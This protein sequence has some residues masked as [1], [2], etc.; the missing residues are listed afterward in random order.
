MGKIWRRTRD[1]LAIKHQVPQLKQIPLRNLRQYY[2]TN[3]CAKTKDTLKIKQQLGYKE[4]ETTLIYTKLIAS[5]KK[6]TTLAK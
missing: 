2:G 5:T 3:F 6:M 4:I 1:K